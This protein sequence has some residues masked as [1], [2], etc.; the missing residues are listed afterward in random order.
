MKILFIQDSLGTG[1]AE[2]SNAHLWYYL[3]DKGV[4]LKIAVLEHRKVGIEEEI[5]K[6]GF[7]VHFV[8]EKD[9]F[10]QSKEIA[11]LI[12]EFS[13][14]LVHTVLFKATLRTRFAKLFTSF[15]HIESLVNCTYDTVRLTDSR[16]SKKA[17]YFY[18]Y[19]DN[20][21]GKLFTDKFIPITKVVHDHY[22]NELGI[23]PN[24]MNV[25][26]RGRQENQLI[27]S[28]EKL[29][30]KVGK[31]LGI[32][33][34]NIIITHVGRQEF[35][36]GHLVLLKAIESLNANDKSKVSFL[37]FGR[38]GNVSEDIK[39]FLNA[40]ILGADIHWMG[41]RN[42]VAKFLA[43]TDIFVFPSFYEGLGGS[44]IEAQ[45]AALPIICTDIPVLNEVVDKDGNAL[46]FKKNDHLELSDKLSHLINNEKLRA[47]M[48][49][50]SLQRFRSKFKIED[51]HQEVFSYYQEIIDSSR[52]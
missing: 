29:K 23:H 47:E 14:D 3:R 48:G 46:L 22:Q 35:Q 43:V 49:K 5:L 45:A 13:P 15:V 39:S 10:N 18:K 11:G 9:F 1:G 36:K 17:F 32:P 26:Y 30:D 21:T 25:I 19:L 38:E 20:I 41:H 16:I 37:F 42:D 4:E 34:D 50:K 7:D 51:I 33:E 6:A 12:R 31:E 52:R 2:R 27:Q 28:K 24:K 44:L 8:K 40:N